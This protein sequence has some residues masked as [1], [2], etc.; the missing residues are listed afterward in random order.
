M[1]GIPE[2]IIKVGFIIAVVFVIYFAL[3]EIITRIL[4]YIHQ[5]RSLK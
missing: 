1:F 2:W 4:W 5:K 3:C